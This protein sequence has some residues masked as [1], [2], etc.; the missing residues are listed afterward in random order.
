MWDSFVWD[1]LTNKTRA[2]AKWIAGA[3]VLIHALLLLSAAAPSTNIFSPLSPQIKGPTFDEYF[4]ISAGVSYVKTGDF[5]ENR[6]H[7]PL[8]KMMIGAPV[9]ACKDNDFPDQWRD[10]V[11]FPQQYFYEHNG[12]QQARNLYLARLPVVA[13]ALLLDIVMFA[14]AAAMA[15]PL[16]GLA[17][18]AISAFDPSCIAAAA[19][20]NLDF[21]AAAFCFI[22][23]AAFRNAMIKNTAWTVL[24]AGV[25]VGL[26]LLSKLTALLLAPALIAMAASAGYSQKSWRPLLNMIFVGLAAFS[27]FAAGYHFET[28]SLDSVK[29][30]GKFLAKSKDAEGKPNI[31]ERN[32]IRGPILT[33]FGW[34]RGIPLLTAIKGL[35]H[36]LSETGQ[37]GH[38]GYLL[39]E[40]TGIIK[41]KDADTGREYDAFVGWKNYYLAV[42]PQKLPIVSLILIVAGIV[43][44]CWPGRPLVD[45]MFLLV[46]PIIIIVQFSFSNAQLGIKYILPAL[47]PLFIAAATIT[48]RQRLQF[49]VALFAFLG[50]LF[51]TWSIHPDEAMFYSILAGGGDDGA[52]VA[53]VGDDWGQDA[54]ALALFAKDLELTAQKPMISNGFPNNEYMEKWNHVWTPEGNAADGD[55]IAN[56][57]LKSGLA[58]RYYGEG[59]PS[60]YG[61]DFDSLG[62]GPRRGLFAVHTTTLHRENE[63][64]TWLERFDPNATAGE[65][66]P[67]LYKYFVPGRWIVN[68]K[69]FARIGHAILVYYIP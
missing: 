34:H 14:V 42:I 30:H 17:A 69:P 37:I 22:A 9:A 13:L 6:E 66:M 41:K 20:A 5:A 12:E 48:S 44:A 25:C 32:M 16:A 40:S 52:R 59:D 64:F 51:A 43:A 38:A 54:P 50:P 67:G 58:Y 63:Q 56:S 21:P 65:P 4:Y 57:I 35:D 18:L 60:R 39:G 33:F 36:T 2:K 23:L 61:Y 27:T 24:L 3:L 19:T 55:G 10:L 47:F 11:H 49:V 31:L 28:R 15:G 68:H 26:A 8:T 1:S 46:F 53:C 62:I 7:P 29:G 45:R